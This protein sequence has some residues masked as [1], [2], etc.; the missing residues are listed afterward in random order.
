MNKALKIYIAL[1]VLII[2]GIIALDATRPKPIDWRPTFAINDKIPLGLYVLNN[3][4][5][6]LF[7]N[8]KTERFTNTFYEFLNPRFNHIDSSYIVNGT[9]LLIS[10]NDEIDKSSL[11]EL[12]SR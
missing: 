9:I 6:G 11:K 3:E 7:P 12:Y 1:F 8:Q 10:D 5:S 4:L 2:I